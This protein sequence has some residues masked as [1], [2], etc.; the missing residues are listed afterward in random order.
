M[1]LMRARRGRRR[2]RLDLLIGDGLMGG[3]CHKCVSLY[4][5][6]LMMM[7]GNFYHTRRGG[8]VEFRAISSRLSCHFVHNGAK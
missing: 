3:R 2:A 4:D 1:V 8:W 5:T 7:S 6:P